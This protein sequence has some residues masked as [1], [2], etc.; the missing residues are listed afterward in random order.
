MASDLEEILQRF[1]PK[2]LYDELRRDYDRLLVRLGRMEEQLLML[3][4]YRLE[5]EE[6]VDVIDRKI[7]RAE[8]SRRRR[9]R[10]PEREPGPRKEREDE[11]RSAERERRRAAGPEGRKR[12]D[13]ATEL[14]DSLAE[15]S[16]DDLIRRL[17]ER[18]RDISRLRDR[19]R[20]EEE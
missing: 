15:E 4:E 13:L 1:V 16:T 11:P 6:S 3:S 18:Y 8:K 9:M 12:P 7:R 20:D 2:K 10:D 17:R 19:L 5:P 14:E